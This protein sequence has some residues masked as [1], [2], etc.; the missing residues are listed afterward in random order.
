METIDHHLKL[1]K[2]NDQDYKNGIHQGFYKLNAFH[3]YFHTYFIYSAICKLIK[4][5]DIK[6]VVEVGGGEGF[7]V[8]K[9]KLMFPDIT[10]LNVEVSINALKNGKEIFNINDAILG[11]IL[12]LPFRSKSF[13]LVI[14]SEVLEHIEDYKKAIIE[15]RRVASKALLITT[16]ACHSEAEQKRFIPDYDMKRDEHV[17]FFLKEDIQNEFINGAGYHDY[18]HSWFIRGLLSLSKRVPGH[19]ALSNSALLVKFFTYAD[20]LF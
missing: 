7:F 14:C 8:N 10:V 4:H 11:D 13:D 3:T 9:I 2:K 1:M 16:P 15:L 6:S 5:L 20:Y 19:T 12:S 17:H 18:F